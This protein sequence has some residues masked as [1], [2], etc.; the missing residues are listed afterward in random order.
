M[1]CLAPSEPGFQHKGRIWDAHLHLIKPMT[2]G[3]VKNQGS[4]D[5]LRRKPLSEPIYFIYFS[6]NLTPPI[7]NPQEKHERDIKHE[8]PK[9]RCIRSIPGMRP[10]S[11]QVER[12]AELFED[13][14]AQHGVVLRWRE[15][16][17]V[18]L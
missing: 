18:W 17:H 2:S 11:G 16:D 1:S 4:Q 10:L 9:Q 7:F 15:V 6:D 5:I 13:L 14:L 3:A 12:A 8:Y